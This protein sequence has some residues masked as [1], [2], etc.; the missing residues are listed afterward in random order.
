MVHV[1]E[2]EKQRRFEDYFMAQISQM[3]EITKHVE[4]ISTVI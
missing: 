2:A 1:D 3:S 4:A